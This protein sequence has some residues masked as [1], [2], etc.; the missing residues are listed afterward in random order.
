MNEDT[1]SLR[2]TTTVPETT[3]QPNENKLIIEAIQGLLTQVNEQ[4]SKLG[5]LGPT[6][7]ITR[8]RTALVGQMLEDVDLIQHTTLHK[9]AEGKAFE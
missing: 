7:E 9:M 8:E 6:A 2:R 5:V 1:E 4:I 3:E